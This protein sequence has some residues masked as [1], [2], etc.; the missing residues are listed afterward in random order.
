M[1]RLK[2]RLTDQ[3]F[4]MTDDRIVLLSSVRTKMFWPKQANISS[5]HAADVAAEDSQPGCVIH[6][7]LFQPV[8]GVI[9]HAG[10]T[11]PKYS[12]SGMLIDRRFSVAQ[13]TLV[14]MRKQPTT[15]SNRDPINERHLIREPL[16]FS[17]HCA[18]ARRQAFS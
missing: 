8:R 9:S 18:R 13:T 10:S 1:P 11:L 14:Q 7:A 6:F 2:N 5:H 15:R 17:I 4:R 3:G 12:S 16:R